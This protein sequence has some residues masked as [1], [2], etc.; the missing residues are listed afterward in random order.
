MYAA[1]DADDANHAR[2]LSVLRRRDLDLAIPAMVLGEV[3]YL[4]ATRL[5]AMVEPAFLRGLQEFEVIAPLSEDW[6]LIADLVARY[7]DFPLGGTDASVAVL[8][9]RLG[10]HTIITFDHRHFRALTA[11]DG[12]P[13]RLSPG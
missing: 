9:E 1:V 8:A 3:S 7:H 11:R 6:P 13:F 12:R 4:V 10:T 5:G 2:S